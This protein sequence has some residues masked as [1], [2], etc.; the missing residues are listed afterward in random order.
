[1]RH[2]GFWLAIVLSLVFGAAAA[3][4]DKRVALVVGNGTYSK[5][6]RLPNPVNDAN[7]MAAL[8]KAAGFNVVETKL[9]LDKFSSLINRFYFLWVN[10]RVGQKS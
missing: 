6:A 3:H 4:A 5:V 7:A 8:F 1:M 9:D 10:G 2:V